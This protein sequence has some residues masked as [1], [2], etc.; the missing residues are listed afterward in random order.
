MEVVEEHSVEIEVVAQDRVAG[1]PLCPL[2]FPIGVR[3]LSGLAGTRSI[4]TVPSYQD[5]VI[6]STIAMASK[7][8]ESLVTNAFS[9]LVLFSVMISTKYELLKK[10]L[11]KKP[12]I[13][14]VI[15]SEDAF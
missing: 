7:M 15:D 13:F 9:H 3:F 10:L 8:N 1:L 4:P 2:R 11:K 12:Q 5:P 6:Y 14:E